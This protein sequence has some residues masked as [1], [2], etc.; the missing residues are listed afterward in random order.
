MLTLLVVSPIEVVLLEKSEVLM[1]GD[2]LAGADGTGRREDN[3]GGAGSSLGDGALDGVGSNGAG[4]GTEDRKDSLGE[5]DG[6][7]FVQTTL[8]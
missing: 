4:E 5:H 7:D 2:H 6:I 3:L 1:L 8:V